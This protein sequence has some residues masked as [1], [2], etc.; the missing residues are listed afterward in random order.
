MKTSGFTFLLTRFV[1]KLKV[2][3]IFLAIGLAAMVSA[4]DGN[5]RERAPAERSTSRSR[6]PVTVTV[7]GTM[8]VA[9]GM[10]ALRSGDD[11][12]LIGGVSRLIGFIDGLKE[13]AQV[14][15]EGTVITIPGRNNLKYLQGSKL[16]LGGKSYD[17]SSS[18]MGMMPGIRPPA[19]GFPLRNQ[20]PRTPQRR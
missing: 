19:P 12:Y 10:P 18:G 11:T 13:G 20:T 15:V 8:V 7:S 17:L 16:T 14:T 6:T 4:Q 3:F 1:L 9:N 5:R 2:L